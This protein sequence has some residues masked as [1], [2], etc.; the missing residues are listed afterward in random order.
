M[1]PSYHKVNNVKSP[2]EVYTHPDNVQAIVKS[3]SKLKKRPVTY[4]HAFIEPGRVRV[5][6]E[7]GQREREYKN[8][9]ATSLKRLV[10]LVNRKYALMVAY[11]GWSACPDVPEAER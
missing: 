7:R 11:N 9:T 4:I 6:I 8:V 1:A 3:F 10:D 2:D 5:V